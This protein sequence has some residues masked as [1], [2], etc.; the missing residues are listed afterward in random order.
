MNK[1]S[2][3]V[4]GRFAQAAPCAAG[5]LQVRRAISLGLQR[6]H[7]WDFGSGDSRDVVTILSTWT[8]VPS[9][10][11]ALKAGC[12]RCRGFGSWL[13]NVLAVQ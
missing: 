13:V 5:S 6:E 3:I 2:P 1:P 11:A 7:R 9:R 8:Q 4:Q 12:E 10:A